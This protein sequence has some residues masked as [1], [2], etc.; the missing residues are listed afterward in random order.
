M[1]RKQLFLVIVLIMAA[2]LAHIAA[3]EH[4]TVSIKQRS[5]QPQ[6]ELDD[7]SCEELAMLETFELEKPSFF[8]HWAQ[9]IGGA[10]AA[11]YTIIKQVMRRKLNQLKGWWYEQKTS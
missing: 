8:V 6:F 4:E 7:M 5:A 3:Q 11:R 10:V 1:K 2:P 9:K